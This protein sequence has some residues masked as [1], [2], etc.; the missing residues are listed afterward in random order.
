M[1][2]GH[3]NEISYLVVSLF[4]F[5]G[6]EWWNGLIYRFYRAMY[7][8]LMNEE[9]SMDHENEIKTSTGVVRVLLTADN[10]LSTYVPKLSPT[11]LAERRKRLGLAFKRVVDAAI[12]RQAH[13]F[14]QAGDLFDSVDPRNV[15]RDF[16]AQ[17]LR[18]L[19]SAGVHTLGISGNYDTP[20]Q[21]TEQGGFAPQSIYSRLGGMHFFGSSDVI[22]PVL[23][24]VAGL[25]LAIAGLSY[26]PHVPPGGDPLDHV[27]INDPEGVLARVDLGILL[28]HTAFEGQAFPGAMETFAR[29]TSLLKCEGFHIILAGHV[30]R[31]DRF[32][33]GGKKVVVAGATELTEFGHSEEN[34]GFVYLELT[35]DG[36]QHCEHIPTKPQLRHTVMLRTTELWPCPASHEKISPDSS[37]ESEDMVSPLDV[38]PT[39]PVAERIWAYVEPYCVEDAMVRLILEGPLTR[40]QYHELDL[41]T[42]WLQG[43]QRA[44]FF[45]IDESRLFLTNNLSQVVTERGDCIALR[46][47]LEAI[48]LEWMEQ[49]EGSPERLLVSK[50]RQRVLDRYDELSG[51][52]AGR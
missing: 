24:N 50:M 17:Q 34:V 5:V 2:L 29:H 6:R 37:A 3:G 31:Y 40:E 1:A 47:I 51:R 41:C 19:Q 52:E 13:L 15:E 23:L 16:V 9:F 30:H 4:I 49:A 18:R 43:Q 39:L 42:I 33:I 8:Y 21:K 46:E 27:R 38:L 11:K 48:A 7:L 20:R 26:H 14:I 36:L 25:Q 35:R 44:F 32:S 28:L 45:E 22:E 10:H 12:D